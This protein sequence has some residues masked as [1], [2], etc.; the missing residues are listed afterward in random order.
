M[1]RLLVIAALLP[2]VSHAAPRLERVTVEDD[3]AALVLTLTLDAAVP[4]A[5]VSTAVVSDDAVWVVRVDGAVARRRWV[6]LSDPWIRRALILPAR[7][8]PPAALLRVRM[9]TTIPPGS[10]EAA[11]IDVEGARVTVRLPRPGHAAA[12]PLE[13]ATLPPDPPPA[14]PVAPT[15]P[16]PPAAEP[17]PPPPEA[18]A[19]RPAPSAPA[20]PVRDAPAQPATTVTEGLDRLD[21]TVHAGLRRAAELPRVALLP[22]ERI[23]REGDAADLAGPATAAVQA[24]L[25]RR[26]L[27]FRVDDAAART[28]RRRYLRGRAEGL[29]S[30]EAA[31]LGGM[32]GADAVVTGTVAVTGGTVEV[33]ARVLDTASGQLLAEARAPFP[34]EDFTAFA[35]AITVEDTRAGAALR[36]ALLPGW[37]QLHRDEVGRGAAYVTLF[38]TLL[39]VGLTSAALG[40]AAESDY[41]GGDDAASLARRSDADAH[42]DRA[43][44]F[45]LGA[46]T[47]WLTALV[48]TL[49]TA[50]PR[51]RYA[52]ERWEEAR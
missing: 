42:Y 16:D 24:R 30:A 22:F 34:R 20:P 40:H 12:A 44:V 46:G 49:V 15:P 9:K 41:R 17:P 26:P 14:P 47:L 5:A 3:E 4:A 7:T 36:S 45:L 32:L 1:I 23:D 43:N 52:P 29:D 8:P 19:R 37:A 33:R 25:D 38:A 18:P 27:V 11:V 13:P 31:T 28:A 21:R 39:S 2:A 10:A 50:E 6:T 51:I 35:D 48:D